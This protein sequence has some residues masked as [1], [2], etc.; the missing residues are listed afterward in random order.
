MSKQDLI[1]IGNRS[2][3]AAAA[4]RDQG[5]Y[6]AAERFLSTAEYYWNFAA[7]LPRVDQ[8]GCGHD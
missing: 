4:M 2:S 6:Q 1:E 7:K 8:E 5:D 3:R